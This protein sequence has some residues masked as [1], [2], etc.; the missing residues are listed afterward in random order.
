MG[1]NKV[2]DRA[3]EVV[4]EAAAGAREVLDEGLDEARE[5]FEEAAEDL[6]RSARRTQREMRRRAE[7][8][9]EAAR[10][11]YDAAVDGV[12]AGYQRV[13]KDAGELADDVNAYVRENPG[14][15][16]LIA[17]GVGFALGMLLRGRRRDDG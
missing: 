16:I 15:S 10:E 12:K 1:D 13:R 4:S 7:H 5:R 14:K 8:F 2:V 3:R 17:A 9:G 11:R 6:G